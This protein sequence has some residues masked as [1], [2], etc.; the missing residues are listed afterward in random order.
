[1]HI[2]SSH[3][4]LAA[5]AE[6]LQ[7]AE[8]VA[9][10]LHPATDYVHVVNRSDLLGCALEAVP[11]SYRNPVLKVLERCSR[12]GERIWSKIAAALQTGECQLP[13]R[14]I[15]A[16]APFHG[17]C[18]SQTLIRNSIHVLNLFPR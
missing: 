2:G 18:S 6:C 12:A 15:D 3:L 11:E 5:E 13:R 17:P 7:L 10:K 14:Y 1:M 4:P 9:N 8:E 16:L